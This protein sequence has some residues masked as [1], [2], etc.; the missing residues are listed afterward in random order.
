[1]AHGSRSLRVFAGTSLL[2]LAGTAVLNA[3]SPA[4]GEVEFFEKKVR[5]VLV[6]H[7]YKCHSARAKKLKG[8]LRLDNREALLKGGD[9]GPA[10]VPGQPD[11]SRL[12]EVVRYQSVDLR[13]P[14]RGKLPDS[15]IA[16]LTRWVQMGV[17]WPHEAAAQS[18][19]VVKKAFDLQQ[20]K[21]QHWAWQ[22]VR[23]QTPPA[24]AHSAW[25]RQ[26]VDCFILAKLESKGLMPAPPA[27]KRTLLRRLS[28]DLVGLPPTPADIEAFLRDSSPDALEKVVD[29]LLASPQF[30]ERWARHWLDLVRYAET[31]GHEFD[32][33]LPNAYEYRNYVIRALNADLPYNRF[34]QE[35]IAGDLLPRPRLHPTE[36]FNESILGT[37]F[38]LLGEELHSPVD[39][40]QDEADRLDNKIDV[41]TKTFLGLTVAC[42]RCHNHKFDAISTRDYYALAGFLESSNYR[43]VRFDT[44]EHNRRVARDL[45]RLRERSRPLV[46]RAV[47]ETLR[48]GV[49]RLADY[50]LA[51]REVMMIQQ[52]TDVLP[53]LGLEVIARAHHLD[54]ARL[55]QWLAYLSRA[56]RDPQDPLHAWA[57]MAWDAGAAKRV[58]PPLLDSWS[59]RAA[60]AKTALDL[61][62][63]VVDYRAANPADWMPDGV[64]FGP[65]PVRAGEIRFGS[66]P[67][68]PIAAL[69]EQAAAEK[70]PT[71]DRLKLRPGSELDP[72]ALGALVRSGRSLCTPSF[73]LTT[74]KLFY[75]VRGTGRAYAA[76]D[77]HALIAGPLH[78]RLLNHFKAGNQFRWVAHDLSPYKG[79]RTHIEFTPAAGA[80]FA[81]ALVVQAE[82]MPAPPESPNNALQTL[83]R[84]ADSPKALAAGYQ[85]LFL[86]VTD[87]LAAD[88]VIGADDATEYAGLANWLI[89]H[90]DLLV[91]DR[92]AA[93]KHVTRVATPFF[94]ARDSLLAQIHDESR[95]ALAMQDGRGVNEHVFIRGSPKNL[96]EL[97][98]R[99]F[100]EALAGP[101]PLTIAHGSGRL[102]LAR[103]MTDPAVNPLIARVLVNRVWHHLFGRGIVA[104]VDNFGVLGEPPTHPELLD[105]LAGEFVRQGWSIKKLIRSL[106]LSSTYQMSSRPDDRADAADPQNRLWHRMRLRRLEGEAIRDAMLAVSGRL[107]R[108]L[109]GPSVPVY[110]T[111]FQDGRGRPPSGPLDGNGRR[112][113][114]LA[115]RRNF[116]SSFLL[117]F[118]TP[119]PF[120]TVGRR[121]VSNV[122]AQA[123]ILMNDPFVHQQ[124]A[125]WAWRVLEEAGTPEERI[126]RMYVSA[127]GRPPSAIELSRC[128]EFLKRQGG[129]ESD[130]ATWA[131]LAHVLFNVKEFI[132]IN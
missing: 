126:G 45:W 75:L 80:D 103:Q 131:D 111:S 124:A 6:Q 68:R 108:R 107:D 19:A 53:H 37:G 101:K 104:S 38:W 25:P 100:L 94:A 129:N 18:P 85:R 56:A 74:G 10:V 130:V 63:V 76:V 14:P 95:L 88:K 59:R 102:E 105:Y 58:L 120:S 81:V 67:A 5:P 64:S 9:S 47:A 7:C 13:M 62:E 69:Y 110:L 96:G 27:D 115:V 21:Q 106:V 91:V 40:R 20:R 35:Q 41:L 93:H 17:P 65:G 61:A 11:K 49:E 86:E 16:D 114:Y 48:P 55:E 42:A 60:A 26:P 71:W 83:L 24:V 1:M 52:W 127:F 113:L 30:G 116:L 66:D 128:L 4:P 122:P 54:T 44:L 90:A 57:V 51:A 2:L 87:R 29:R 28:F 43:L 132:F 89:R 31:R 79:H 98:P 70:D 125:V 77:S 84:A 121:T 32:Y 22:P 39:T 119:I 33:V 73:V 23:P 46:Q 118:D 99:R 3:A 12:L 97:V 72:G 92:T 15:I 123:L 82:R 117:A 112:S 50:L 36:G 34:V 8:G 78:G 109:Y